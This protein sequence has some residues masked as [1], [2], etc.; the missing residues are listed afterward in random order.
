MKIFN[1]EGVLAV[2]APTPIAMAPIRRG[3]IKRWRTPMPSD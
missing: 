3:D 2:A 1:G